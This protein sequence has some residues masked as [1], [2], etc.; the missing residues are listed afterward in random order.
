SERSR[1]RDRGGRPARTAGGGD[2]T[3]ARAQQRLGCPVASGDENESAG[4]TQRFGGWRLED[5]RRALCPLSWVRRA[6]N[7]TCAR[8]G[9]PGRAAS[10]RRRALLEDQRRKHSRGHA[11]VQLSARDA[12]L[13]ARVAFACARILMKQ[14]SRSS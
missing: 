6:R 10:E 14:V 2:R 8:P 4:G 1:L 3:S 13:A 11:F 12:A 9:H 5:V 7:R